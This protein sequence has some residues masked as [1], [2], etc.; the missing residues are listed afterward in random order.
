MSYRSQDQLT[1]DV[2]FQGRV[3]ACSVQQ[4]GIFVNDARPDYVALA[5]DVLR[6]GRGPDFTRVAA[7]GPGVA[8]SVD[9][10]NGIID[11]SLVT[12]EALLSLVQGNWPVVA[13]L[14]YDAEGNRLPATAPGA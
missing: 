3:R 10:G 14:Y 7:A 13:A 11:S 6:G 4:A 2:G 8:E 9:I 1:G 12:D 5:H